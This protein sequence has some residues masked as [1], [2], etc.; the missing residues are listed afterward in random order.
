MKVKLNVLERM[1]WKLSCLLMDLEI[2]IRDSICNK[3][4]PEKVFNTRCYNRKNCDEI[5][6]TNEDES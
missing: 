2:S 1:L 5:I 6:F 4:D 3:Y